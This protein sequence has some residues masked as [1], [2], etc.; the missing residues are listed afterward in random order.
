MGTPELA[1]ILCAYRR[2]EYLA[3][4]I[5]SVLQQTVPRDRLEI[6]VLT[7]FEDP[8]LERVLKDQGIRHRIDREERIGK[9]L[10]GA[11]DETR[12]PLVTIVEDDDRLE[13]G[14][15][16][17]VL[18]LFREHPELAYHRNRLSV[19]GPDDRWVPRAHWLGIESERALDRLGPLLIEPTQKDV[20]IGR[21]RA[22]GLE[23]LNLST[24]V[25][26]R[27]ILSP[28]L[29]PAIAASQCPDLFTFVA[30]VLSPGA[31][32]L[33]DQRL[34]RYRRHPKGSTRSLA[35]RRLH[36]AD[37]E[38]FAAIARTRG[39]PSLA[40]W[41]E[42]RSRMLHHVVE[43]GEVLAPVRAEAPPGESVS[44]TRRYLRSLAR[45]PPLASPAALRWSAGAIASGYQVAP[46]LAR[47]VLLACDRWFDLP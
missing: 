20:G 3:G 26:R 41:L 11:V 5:A 28:E 32:Y 35:W 39:P 40:S 44:V 23:W 29:R 22:E 7:D 45:D 12:A 47:N 30:A 10:L 13:P 21:M 6:L 38:R 42:S 18:G 33:D 46:H 25:F 36:W 27:E 16:G 8:S 15:F 17:R 4:A 1:V 24:M 34:T 14:R 2:Q 43:A 9:W 31:L 37:H 19:I